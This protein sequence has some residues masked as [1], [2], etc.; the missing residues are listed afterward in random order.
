MSYEIYE[1]DL[2]DLDG[3]V[4]RVGE[5][6]EMLRSTTEAVGPDGA[7]VL[8]ILPRGKIRSFLARAHRG[9]L[10]PAA[11]LC[12][13]ER[14]A[15]ARGSFES[16]DGRLDFIDALMQAKMKHD[17][18]SIWGGKA[19]VDLDTIDRRHP[20]ARVFMVV[21]DGRDILASRR[22]VGSFDANAEQVA[23]DWVGAL[24]A[25]ETF[26]ERHEGPALQIEYEKLV[27]D[28]EAVLQDACNSIGIAFEPSMLAYEKMPLTLLEHPYG[29]LSAD[30]VSQGINANTVGRWRIEL[31]ASSISAFEAVAADKLAAFGYRL[32]G[33]ASS[34]P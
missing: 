25:F 9:G 30:R 17:S 1:E 31:D 12:E 6:L 5:V 4:A 29:H 13:L 26:V 21:R 16:L 10:A 3:N 24:N 22:K 34:R 27:E 28:P 14:F 11:V 2:R 18:K 32:A 20:L 7:A 33:A 23:R 8:R 15:R 19:K